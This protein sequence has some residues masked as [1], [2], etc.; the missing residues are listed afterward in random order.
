[1]TCFPAADILEVIDIATQIDSRVPVVAG[2][3]SHRPSR[4]WSKSSTAL[5]R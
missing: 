1:M 2:S 5:P 4:S 3:N